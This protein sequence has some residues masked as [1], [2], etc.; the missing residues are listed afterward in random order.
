MSSVSVARS[1]SDSTSDSAFTAFAAPAASALAWAAA[2][3]ASSLANVARLASSSVRSVSADRAAV[4]AI[5]ASIA[6]RSASAAAARDLARAA[7]D[8]DAECNGQSP[9]S[10]VV[11]SSSAETH[12]RRREA[13]PDVVSTITSPSRAFE[14]ERTR[15]DS[16]RRRPRAA[17]ALRIF[18][19]ASSPADRPSAAAASEALAAPSRRAPSSRSS[20]D[21][22]EDASEEERSSSR[23]V[24]SGK[25]VRGVD[26]R[27][28]IG[29]HSAPGQHARDRVAR[30]GF[31]GRGGHRGGRRG[32]VARARARTIAASSLRISAS[33]SKSPRLG[34]AAI[35]PHV[36]IACRRDNGQR[37]F[38]S[39]RTPPTRRS[40]HR[41]PGQRRARDDPLDRRAFP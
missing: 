38:I 21:D 4:A 1:G 6:A 40:P 34:S 41:A 10:A 14:S 26:G 23:C 31:C 7:S 15:M 12:G 17:H 30:H 13:T 33:A 25:G 20:S 9:S 2:D 22:E 36:V 3:S 29:Q 8:A 27:G 18:A 19:S 24:V 39:S 16:R 5:S 28:R 37:Q 35:A 32:A 11:L